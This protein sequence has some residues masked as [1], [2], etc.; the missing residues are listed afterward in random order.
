MVL[1]ACRLGAGA[2]AKAEDGVG[3]F[4]KSRLARAQSLMGF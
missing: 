3:L 4:E 1:G 2:S